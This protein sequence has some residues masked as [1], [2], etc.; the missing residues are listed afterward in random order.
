MSRR[1]KTPLRS[2]TPVETRALTRVSQS[3]AARFDQ[4][5]RARAL[6]AVAGGQTFTAAARLA[7]FRSS[8]AVSLLVARFNQHGLAALTIAPGR[9]RRPTYDAVARTA[10][11]A[12]LQQ[13]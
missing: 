11:L 2:L 4:V 8:E 9:G 13:A 12:R 1:Q 5:Q 3:R 10:L 7:G 6:L